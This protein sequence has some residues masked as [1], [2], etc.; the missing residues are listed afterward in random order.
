MTVKELKTHLDLF[1]D[2]AVVEIWEWVGR[3]DWRECKIGDNVQHQI[4]HQIVM[5]IRGRL[6]P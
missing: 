5:L 2:D 4:Q 3:D 6:L 1:K